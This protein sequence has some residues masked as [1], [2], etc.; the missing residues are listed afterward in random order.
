[1]S[2]LKAVPAQ[3]PDDAEKFA[4][5]ASD[6]AALCDD[7]IAT[8]EI[9]ALSN[10]ALGQVMASVV[11]LY[12]AKAENG[13]KLMPFGRNSVPTPTDVCITS[14]ALLDAGGIEVFELGLWETMSNIRP[15][16][17]TGLADAS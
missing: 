9:E 13:A 6:I 3:T 1:M 7:A 2:A 10:E 8:G 11:R 14:L 16:K 5:L 17:A 4:S 15:A 12:A